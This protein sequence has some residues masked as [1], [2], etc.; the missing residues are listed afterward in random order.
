MVVL[1][2]V[3]LPERPVPLIVVY[4]AGDIK[5]IFSVMFGVIVLLP[6]P[7]PGVPTG[8][9]TYLSGS[10][11]VSTWVFGEF[12]SNCVMVAGFAVQPAKIIP[13]A[14]SSRMITPCNFINN[15]KLL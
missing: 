15:T 11:G 1:E 9:A 7:V 8:D 12:L 14:R 5:G 13:A 3:V 4:C 6:V 2:F 10:V